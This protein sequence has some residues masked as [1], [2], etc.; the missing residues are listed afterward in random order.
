MNRW[1]GYRS[2]LFDLD[3]TLVDTA[4]DIN[5]ALNYS[6]DQAGLGQVDISLT[7]HWVGHGSRMLIS[8]SLEYLQQQQLDIDPLLGDFLD[9]YRA[10]LAVHS[11]IYPEVTATLIALKQAGARLAVVT[12]KLAELSEPLLAD[13]GLAH[14][15][16]LIVCGDTASAPKPDPAPVNLCLHEFDLPASEVL[17]VGDSDTDVKAAR[18]ANVDVVCVRDGYNHGVDV[19]TLGATGIIDSFSELVG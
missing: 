13:I 12:N 16:D 4:P 18:A 5:A 2:Y 7:R 8:Q 3:G 6:L 10:N 1:S 17:F 11:I 9:Y 19:T 14:H 15:F